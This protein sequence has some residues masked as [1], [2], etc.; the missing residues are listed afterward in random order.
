METKKIDNKAQIIFEHF[1][2]R[3]GGEPNINFRVDD[4]FDLECAYRMAKLEGMD[5]ISNR[6]LGFIKIMQVFVHWVYNG[7]PDKEPADFD[8]A[9]LNIINS[10]NYHDLVVRAEYIYDNWEDINVIMHS[11]CKWCK[12][13]FGESMGCSRF[14]GLDCMFI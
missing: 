14:F 8:E 12:K 11:F 13:H 10:P 1:F 3:R 6:V 4:L 7:K 9:R 2:K 5:G